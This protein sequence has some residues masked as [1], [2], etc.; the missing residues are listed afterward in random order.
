MNSTSAPGRNDPCPCGSGRKYKR[1]CLHADRGSAP[2]TPQG[3][4]VP[5]AIADIFAGIHEALEGRVFESEAEMKGVMNTL[6]DQQQSRP[7]DDFLG[8][9]SDDVHALL[10]TPFDAPDLID[11]V[12]V[13]DH[14]PQAPAMALLDAVTEAI[15]EKGLLA[16]QTGNLPRALC[17]ELFEADLIPEAIDPYRRMRVP[18]RSENDF[19]ELGSVRHTAEFAGLIELRGRR[20]MRTERW[21]RAQRLAGSRAVY[22]ILL[23]TRAVEFN[24]ACEDGHEEL[25]IVQQAWPFLIFLLQR[26]VVGR[27]SSGVIEEAFARAFPATLDELSYLPR[28]QRSGALGRAVTLRGVLRF[29][30]L[31]GL[32]EATRAKPDDPLDDTYWLTPT[33]LLHDAVRFGPAAPAVRS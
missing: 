22:P 33:P 8:L 32:I 9:R 24:W 29:A 26:L 15:G 25:F 2:P 1:C 19:R 11:V 13:L 20:F 14:E 30:A 10:Y 21:A 3:E 27:T 16:T 28:N 5:D 7:I 23:R 12:T 31:F 4:P 6:M 17:R 18:I